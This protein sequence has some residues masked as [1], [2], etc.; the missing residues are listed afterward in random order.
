VARELYRA[1]L[2]LLAVQGVHRALAV[3]TLPNPASVAMHE[4]LGFTRAGVLR[5][6]GW[7]LGRW[8][9][10]GFWEREVASHAGPPAP[11]RALA[12]LT[13]EEVRACLERAGD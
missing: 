11:P 13:A 1:L 3:I 6:A 2:P 5:E 7:K 4:R 9:D 10:V 8:H 12:Q